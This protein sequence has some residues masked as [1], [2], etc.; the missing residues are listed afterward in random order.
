LV[1]T[2]KESFEFTESSEQ[3]S[4]AWSV[5]IFSHQKVTIDENIWADQTF[6][7]NYLQNLDVKGNIFGYESKT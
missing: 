2:F 3:I 6:C 7:Q 1:T 5:E 4:V